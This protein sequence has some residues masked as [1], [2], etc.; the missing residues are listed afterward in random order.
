MKK[1]EQSKST[2]LPKF[3]FNCNGLDNTKK[4]TLK[5]TVKEYDNKDISENLGNS[6]S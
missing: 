2:S 6:R 1:Q 4:I 3:T 5:V